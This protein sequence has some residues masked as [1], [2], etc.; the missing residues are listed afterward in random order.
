MPFSSVLSNLTSP[1]FQLSIHAAGS[2][3]S[4]HVWVGEGEAPRRADTMLCYNLPPPCNL[5]SVEQGGLSKIMSGENLRSLKS[6]QMSFVVRFLS[7]SVSG[8]WDKM[9]D[10]NALKEERFSWVY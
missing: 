1:A 9:F 7:P 5:D 10:R 4:T 3:L 2:K 8:H 6:P